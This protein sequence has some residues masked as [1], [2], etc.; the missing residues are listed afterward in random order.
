MQTPADAAAYESCEA[1]ADGIG[2][3][4]HF[5][6]R[7]AWFGVIATHSNFTLNGM[8][9][10]GEGYVLARMG[11]VHICSLVPYGVRVP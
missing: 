11:P 4:A 1:D 7:C 10:F 5:I 9:L 2:T 3:H 8:Q 6:T